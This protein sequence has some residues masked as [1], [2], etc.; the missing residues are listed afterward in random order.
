M[1]KCNGNLL[2]TTLTITKLVQPNKIQPRHEM[3][4][5]VTLFTDK[6]VQLD[7]WW[8][9]ALFIGT[10]CTMVHWRGWK[11]GDPL[12]CDLNAMESRFSTLTE[13]MNWFQNIGSGRENRF[14]YNCWKCH[15]C[16]PTIEMAQDF[17]HFSVCLSLSLTR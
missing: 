16:F 10:S 8:N 12:R 2:T 13:R 4:S 15:N 3:I 14:W 9:G 11:R 6:L 7:G 17:K 1:W 5:Y